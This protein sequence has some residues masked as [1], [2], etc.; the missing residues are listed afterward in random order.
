MFE[1]IWSGWNLGQVVNLGERSEAPVEFP[2]TFVTAGHCRIVELRESSTHLFDYT[3]GP[4]R[5]VVGVRFGPPA[6]T[7]K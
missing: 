5:T 4:L 6:A 3:L 1:T 7:R 2:R